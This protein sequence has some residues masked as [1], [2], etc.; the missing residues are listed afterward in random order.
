MYE[1]E[2]ETISLWALVFFCLTKDE[3]LG[4]LEYHKALKRLQPY[5]LETRGDYVLIRGL[6][7]AE[8][9]DVLLE[10]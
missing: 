3:N 7:M 1:I 2:E 6:S 9:E 10:K 5:I 8:V 4:F